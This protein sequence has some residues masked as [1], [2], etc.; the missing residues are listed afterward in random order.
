MHK[1]ANLGQGIRERSGDQTGA[2]WSEPLPGSIAFETPQ[3]D[4]DWQSRDARPEPPAKPASLTHG[5]GRYGGYAN[6]RVTIL[7]KLR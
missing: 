1:L 6:R 4:D 3:S 7:G 5:K 2:G